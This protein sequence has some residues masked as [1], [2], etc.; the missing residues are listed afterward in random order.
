MA[1][2]FLRAKE[3]NGLN[4]GEKFSLTSKSILVLFILLI[5]ICVGVRLWAENKKSEVPYQ[6]LTC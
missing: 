2:V 6:V 5:F 1:E 3:R 4:I